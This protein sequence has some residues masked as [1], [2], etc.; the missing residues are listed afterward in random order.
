MKISINTNKIY[1]TW[2]HVE[3]YQNTTLRYTP[4][5]KFPAIMEEIIGRP[6][7]IRLFI[8]LDEIWDYRTNTYHWNHLIGENIYKDDP[9]HYDYDWPLTVPSPTGTH[10]QE[11][12]ISHAN[13]ADKVLLNIR[14]YEREVTDGLV[15]YETYE[16]VVYNVLKYFKNLIPNIVYIESCNEVELPQF[17]GLSMEEYYKLY[18]RSANVV[19]RL[20][21]ENAYD[22]PLQ[23]GGFGMAFGIAHWNYWYD[24]L[25]LLSTD[26]NRKIDFYSMHEYDTNILR[27]PEFYTLH[28]ES[29]RLLNLPDLPIFM[30]EYGLRNCPG[31]IGRP[32]HMQ[33]ASGE[34]SGF[35]ISSHC[36][37]LKVF[38]WCTFHNPSQQIGRTMFILQ[39]DNYY[40]TPNGHVMTFF[41]ELGNNELEIDEYTKYNCVATIQDG[42]IKI[43]VSSP[44]QEEQIDFTFYNLDNDDYHVSSFY[45]DEYTNNILTD[46]TAT[47]LRCT[48]SK[49]YVV[50]NHKLELSMIFAKE[51]FCL[52]TIKRK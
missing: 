15:S 29:I 43:L 28:Q 49:D 33:N 37:K 7:I 47:S 27:I 34:I 42:V 48:F 51:S 52:I 12:L 36:H 19:E 3:K 30:T 45:V 40:A 50:T 1:R 41:K 21:K 23:I 26:K 13:H 6:E 38:P 32:S 20:N 5:K 8:T 18:K 22:E 2:E 14:R 39:D 46:S 11:Y 25:K 31:D 10:I 4:S 24:F 35:I 17:G 9:N 16:E 44:S